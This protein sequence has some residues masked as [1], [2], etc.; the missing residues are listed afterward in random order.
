MS[1]AKGD[2]GVITVEMDIQKNNN[3]NNNRKHS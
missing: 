3:I 1:R 2:K